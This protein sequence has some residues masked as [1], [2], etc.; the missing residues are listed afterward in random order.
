[1]CLYSVCLK[2][3]QKEILYSLY[4]FEIIFRKMVVK[5]DI[6]RIVIIMFLL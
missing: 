5:I 1:M 2:G 3:L 4:K 6:M